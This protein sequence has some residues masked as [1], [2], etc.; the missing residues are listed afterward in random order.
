MNVSCQIE[1]EW[2]DI[3]EMTV[4]VGVRR[5][6]LF[7]SSLLFSTQHVRLFYQEAAPVHLVL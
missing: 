3:R 7:N 5:K 6:L 4:V 1:S 2:E